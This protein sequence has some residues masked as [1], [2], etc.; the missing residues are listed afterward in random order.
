[1]IIQGYKTDSWCQKA[2]HTKMD[3]LTVK[4]NLLFFKDYL[5]ILHTG[6]V[7]ETILTIAHNTLGHFG[8]DKTYD[9]LKDT[10]YWP[11]M[12]TFL[13]LAYIPGCLDCQWNKAPTIKTMRPLHPLPIPDGCFKSVAMDFVGPLPEEDGC[14]TILTIKDCLGVDICLIPCCIDLTV[15]DLVELFF[16]HW[17]CK[18]G[19]LDEIISLAFLER[20]HVIDESGS[21]NGYSISP[22]NGWQFG[23][24]NKTWNQLL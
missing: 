12:H 17:Y 2:L 3:G 11:G 20:P 13:E 15:N 6:N 7:R 10:F 8:F 1:V 9:I 14:N 24:T 21:K 5:V 19:L 22:T 16:T 23:S 18:N 4:G